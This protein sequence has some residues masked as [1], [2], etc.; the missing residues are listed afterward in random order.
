L[1]ILITIIVLCQNYHDIMS[2]VR[3][4]RHLI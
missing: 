4:F 1:T 3:A 2:A